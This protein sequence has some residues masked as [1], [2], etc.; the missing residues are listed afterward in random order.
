MQKADTK[1]SDINMYIEHLILFISF[2]IAITNTNDYLFIAGSLLALLLSYRI[3]GRYV[4]LSIVDICILA[5]WIYLLIGHFISINFIK[6]FWE[7]KVFTN[8]ILFYFLLRFRYQ[9]NFNIRKLLL[10]FCILAGILYLISTTSFFIFSEQIHQTGFD[11]LYDFRFKYRPLGI[12]PNVWSTLLIA[13]QGIIVSSMYYY[14]DNKRIL[15]ILIL[16]LTLNIFGIIVSFSRGIYLSFIFLIISYLFFLVKAKIK[17]IFLLLAIIPLIFFVTPYHSDIIKTI[18]FNKTLSQ[19]RSI[20]GRLDAIK[21]TRGVIREAPLTGVGA[22]NFCLAINEFRY[23]DDNNDFTSFAPNSF[24]QI[25][26]EQ[27]IIGILLWTI[28]IATLLIQFI[29]F[30]NSIVLNGIIFTS[31]LAMLIRELT[32]PAFLNNSGVMLIGFIL[33]ALFQNSNL[34]Y[35]FSIKVSRYFILSL[36]LV[37]ISII[38]ISVKHS[39]NE[40][41]NNLFIQ[42]FHAGK[43]NLAENYINKTSESV[44]YLFNRSVLNH[45]LF[46]QTNDTLYLK[47]MKQNLIQAF[48]KNHRDN[49]LKYHL[50]LALIE[51]RQVDSALHIFNELTTRFPNNTL[52]NVS[53][54][55]NLYNAG[56]KNKAEK[57]LIKAIELFPGIINSE[58]WT[59][60]EKND[61]IYIKKITNRLLSDISS[62]ENSE[63]KT[64]PITLAKIG[65]ILFL[66]GKNASSEKYLKKVVRI[67]P[68]LIMPWYHLGQIEAAKGNT[69]QANQYYINSLSLMG[70][71]RDIEFIKSII[72]SGKTHLYINKNISLYLNYS[73]KF[74][75]W[76]QSTPLIV[77]N[78]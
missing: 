19:Q 66:L 20:S 37:F 40:K 32:F 14:R 9:Q 53:Y 13:F 16:I 1:S 24:T 28:L 34:V 17:I 71:Y 61:S 43:F 23:E 35:S 18:Q 62:K 64:N 22:G 75:N 76:Y 5:L 74:H 38:F 7:F 39:Q 12:F 59:N 70:N 52:Y 50:G 44:P 48:S 30:R 72:H 31:L 41:N 56:E 51:E 29:V 55:E 63:L 47:K 78:N 26:T 21:H 10:S 45:T 25:I 58:L 77:E 46:R 65:K 54:F 67:L 42:A 8:T 15:G 3:H 27:G 60:I 33:I 6:S 68:N 57:Y 2:Y 11:N 36:I 49:M 4:R 69:E 73:S